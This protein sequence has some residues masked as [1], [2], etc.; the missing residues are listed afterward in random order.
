MIHIALLDDNPLFLHQARDFVW[1]ILKKNNIG[2]TVQAFEDANHLSLKD[3][4]YFDIFILDIDF[5]G[6]DLS[7]IDIA[8]RIRQVRQDSVLIFLTNYIEYAPE[9]YEVQAFRYLLKSDI[10]Q[11]L[12][13]YLLEAKKYLQDQ[14]E[15]ICIRHNGEEINL[16]VQQILYIESQKHVAVFHVQNSKNSTCQYRLFMSLKDLELQLSER[17]FLRIQKSYLVNMNRVVKF[18][19]EG[20]TLD[21]G[22]VLPISEKNYSMLKARYMLWKG[23]R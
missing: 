6:K 3:L 7:G 19:C 18:R 2:A 21:N 4:S 9:G 5:P 14:N 16:Q 8:K 15:I 17:G 22:I 23:L 12:G 20:I 10:T 13:L 1:E 11:K